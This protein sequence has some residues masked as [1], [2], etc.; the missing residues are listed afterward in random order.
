LVVEDGRVARRA[1]TI[2]IRG[3]GATEI[4]SGLEPGR[5]VVLA[6]ERALVDGQRVRPASGAR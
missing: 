1:V 2:G 4:T 5:E 6:T 3:G